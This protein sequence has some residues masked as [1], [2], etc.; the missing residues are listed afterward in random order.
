MYPVQWFLENGQADNRL[1]RGLL[2]ELELQERSLNGGE[3][4]ADEEDE[5]EQLLA[6]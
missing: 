4:P 3:L 6:T 5:L 1:A 2:N